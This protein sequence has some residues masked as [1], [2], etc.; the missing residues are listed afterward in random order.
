MPRGAYWHPICFYGMCM[1]SLNRVVCNRYS[2]YMVPTSLNIRTARLV[3][4]TRTFLAVYV[5]GM[6]KGLKKYHVSDCREVSVESL[7]GRSHL[8]P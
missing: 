3:N 2:T 6:A 5:I 8:A 4:K 1:L 7:I